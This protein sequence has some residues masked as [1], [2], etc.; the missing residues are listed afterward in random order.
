MYIAVRNLYKCSMTEPGFI[1]SIQKLERVPRE[2]RESVQRV[3][4]AIPCY[5][6][7]KGIHELE[8][9]FRELGIAEKDYVRKYFSNNKFKFI[10]KEEE[11]ITDPSTMP[12]EKLSYCGT[13]RIM[14]P[15]RA[16]HCNDCNACVEIHD[17]HCPWV[18]TCIGYRNGRYFSYFL[19]AVGIHSLISCALCLFV[20]LLLRW[21]KDD[22]VAGETVL[23][24]KDDN[25][26]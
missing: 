10:R 9:T 14:R 5:V 11:N 3:N 15:P 2:F 21:Q 22:I 23:Q 25:R 16:F 20:F 18:G 4:G 17:H 1:P 12:Y 19:M 8:E 6:S 7:Y 24:P 26:I 13:C